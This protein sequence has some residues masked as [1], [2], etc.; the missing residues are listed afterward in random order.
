LFSTFWSRL[1]DT[2]EHTLHEF[3]KDASAKG[4]LN[5]RGVGNIVEVDFPGF[6]S[7]KDREM[8]NE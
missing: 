2:P 7:P 5:Y 6:L 1:L 8:L 4:L 3:A